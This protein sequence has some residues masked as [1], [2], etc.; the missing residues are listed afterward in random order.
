MLPV[1]HSFEVEAAQGAAHEEEHDD[2]LHGVG[3]G[4]R[5]HGDAEEDG[6][7][8]REIYDADGVFLGGGEDG[9]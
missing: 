9:D 4:G 8:D 5:L 3:L 1:S 6:G 7:L 2:R